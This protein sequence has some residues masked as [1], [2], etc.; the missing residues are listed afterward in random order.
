MVISSEKKTVS[1]FMPYLCAFFYVV[2]AVCIIL[3]L[4]HPESILICSIVGI[5][6]S[7]FLLVVGIKF[8]WYICAELKESDKGIIYE[9]TEVLD[10]MGNQKT[11]YTIRKVSGVVVKKSKLIIT[12]DITC[13]EPMCKE[14]SVKKLV[15]KDYNEKVL[16]FFKNS[17]FNE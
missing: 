14:K 1:N 15:I 5:P 11:R 12:G 17:K 3:S 13:K 10:M 7:I 8:S 9:I 6:I 4:C 16:N 2:V